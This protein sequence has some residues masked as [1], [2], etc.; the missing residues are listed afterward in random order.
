MPGNLS[1]SPS[2][3]SAYNRVRR[4]HWDEVARTRASRF[5]WSRTYHDRLASVLRQAVAPGQRILQVACGDGELLAALQPSFGV[6]VDFSSGM[7]RRGRERFPHLRLVQADAHALPFSSSFDIVVLSDAVNDLWDVQ[8]ALEEIRRVSHPRTRII[9]NTYNRLWEVPLDAVRALGLADAMLPQNWLTVRDMHNLL[10][11]A[12]LEPLRRWSEVLC[13]IEVPGVKTV[14]NRVLVKIWPF[15][16]LGLT[17]IIVA[18]PA[19]HRSA[20]AQPSVSVIVPARN[21]AGHIESLFQRMPRLG[22]RTELVFVEGHSSDAT[23]EAIEQAIGRHPEQS[24]ALYRQKGKGKGDAVRL[25]FANATG[26][27]LMILDA[28]LT[29]APED[30]PRFLE[31]ITNGKADFVNGTRLVYPMADRAMNFFNLIGNKLFS[32]AFSW[33]LGQPIKDTLCGT[34]A[35]RRVDYEKIAANRAYFGEFDP[36]GDYDLL[37][38]AARLGLKIVDLPIRYGA[39]TYGT[40]NIQRW[41]HGVLLLRMVAVAARRLKFV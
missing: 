33:L 13:P 40:T 2:N 31:P 21:E 25:G 28:D 29:V 26:D 27:V 16:A 10:H 35:L 19:P 5:R 39:R 9:I 6:G 18:R 41:R 24:C 37:F 30:L 36:F 12:D 8:Q 3:W 11:L 23:Y 34:K 15:T 7:L 38:G 4:K 22:A 17:N 14:A 1:V 20:G 32:L